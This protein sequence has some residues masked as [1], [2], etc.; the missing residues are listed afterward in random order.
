[1]AKYYETLRLEQTGTVLFAT[2]DA[3][4]KNMLG[5]EL[6]RDLVSLIEPWTRASRTRSLSLRALTLTTSSHMST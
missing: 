2:I 3:P 5:P 6:V 4:P 1:M